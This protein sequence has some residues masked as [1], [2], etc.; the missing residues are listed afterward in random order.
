MI[1][2]ELIIDVL[3]IRTKNLS[4]SIKNAQNSK[5]VEK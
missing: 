1:D 2:C 5:Y 3:N 4:F